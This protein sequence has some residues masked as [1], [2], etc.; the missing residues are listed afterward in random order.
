MTAGSSAQTANVP[1]QIFV[2]AGSSAQTANVPL[3]I[4]VTAGSSAQTANVPLQIKGQFV[5]RLGRS[6]T[7]TGTT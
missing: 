6:S 1:L 4:F 5:D 3:Q 2:T 7:L